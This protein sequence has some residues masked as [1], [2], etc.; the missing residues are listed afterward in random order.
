M[1]PSTWWRFGIRSGLVFP[2]RDGLPWRSHDWKNWTRRVWYP[3]RAGAGIQSLP[4]YDLRHAF[5]SLQ[6]RAGVSVPEL[7]EQMG[8][9]AAMTIG[10]YTHVIRELKGEPLVP[11]EEPIERAR[12]E[13]RGRPGDAEAAGAGA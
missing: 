6:I 12:E 10:T 11:A 5:A 8:H 13:R 1:S 4:P 9:A 3:A 7:A 2:R